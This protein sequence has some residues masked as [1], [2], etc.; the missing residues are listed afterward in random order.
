MNLISVL[1]GLLPESVYFTLFLIFAKQIKQYRVS[2]FLAIFA[3]NI[4]I[5]YFL[6]FSIWYH[7][8]F[9]FLMY[10]TIRI[11]Y[12]AQIIDVFLITVSALI[13]TLLGYACYFLI[14]NYWV[15]AVI[16]RAGLFVVLFAGKTYWNKLYLLYRSGWNRRD[17]ARIKSLTVRNISCV[18][19]N[20]LLYSLN[21]LAITIQ[22][23]F[24]T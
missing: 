13:V 12:K 9:M 10:L 5:S 20:L 18:T 6:A 15:A 3:F 7:V 16:N 8:T 19:L 4:G 21:I 1:F 11:L 23:R 17:G 2:L 14:P 22:N 24:A